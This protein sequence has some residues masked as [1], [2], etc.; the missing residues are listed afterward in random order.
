MPTTEERLADTQATLAA[1]LSERDAIRV[2]N[3]RL[4]FEL[5]SAK[6]NTQAIVATVEHLRQTVRIL[7][8]QLGHVERAVAALTTDG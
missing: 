3:H 6:G 1:V 5:A 4:N 8:E 7:S 2:E